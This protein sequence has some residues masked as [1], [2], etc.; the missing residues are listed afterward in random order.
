MHVDQAQPA[1]EAV[2]QAADHD[3]LAEAAGF[4]L[5]G[6]DQHGRADRRLGPKLAILGVPTP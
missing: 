1:A 6:R 3:L 2:E 4:G 5:D